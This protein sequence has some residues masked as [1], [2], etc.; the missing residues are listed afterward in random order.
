MNGVRLKPIAIIA[1]RAPA[2]V[3]ALCKIRIQL[4]PDIAPR[5]APVLGFEALDD[6]IP[7]VETLDDL[8]I[9]LPHR[10]LQF[11]RFED[12]DQCVGE[13]LRGT[14]RYLPPALLVH[15]VSGSAG[16]GHDDR[17]PRCHRLQQRHP[18]R[19][20]EGGHAENR[21]LPQQL[22]N[23]RPLD[24]VS[25]VDVFAL[26]CDRGDEI[27]AAVS[28]ARDD[29]PAPRETG[30]TASKR[31]R[32]DED[33]LAI[34]DPAE[35]E[36]RRIEIRPPIVGRRRRIECGIDP[37]RQDDDLPPLTPSIDDSAAC[38]GSRYE[39]RGRV[40]LLHC[41]DRPFGVP[42]E[43]AAPSAR[44]PSAELGRPIADVASEDDR[45]VHARNREA[46]PRKDRVELMY[47]IDPPPS[48][49]LLKETADLE[50]I[51]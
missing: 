21:A 35:E 42:N 10:P 46:H 50:H 44:G 12:L 23:V 14:E 9:V 25:D 40:P 34:L 45:Y 30:T 48:S 28:P 19:L 7:I 8:A 11:G 3:S 24:E 31:L 16:I 26:A 18:E 27:L 2:P 47:E 51:A 17:F 29:E 22:R 43:D 20:T 13:S 39:D 41:G 4:P 15:Y 6:A 1:I 49:E 33:P 36:N 5:K 32:Q 38:G 37:V